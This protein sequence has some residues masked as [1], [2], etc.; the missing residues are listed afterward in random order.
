[1]TE[2]MKKQEELTKLLK[3]HC[4]AYYRDDNPELSD[5]EYDQLFLDLKAMEAATG[6]VFPG[7]PTQ[8]V[9]GDCL[10]FFEEVRHNTPM[11]S[12]DNVFNSEELL[13]WLNGLKA[14]IGRDVEY[15]IEPKLDGLA[16]R[17]LYRNGILETAATR[18]DGVVGENVTANARTIWNLPQRLD[19][20]NPPGVYEVSGEVVMSKKR[21]NALN[22]ARVERSEKPFATC[23]N[24]AAGSIRQLDS[25]VA[26]SRG[27]AFYAYQV[28]S[29]TTRLEHVAAM[30]EAASYGF[31][32]ALDVVKLPMR[33]QLG[34]ADLEDLLELWNGVRKEAAYDTDGLVFK[35]NEFVDQEQLGFTG[36]VPRWA[37]AYKFPAKEAT[38]KLRTVDFQV[39]R[40][41][42]ITP[43]ANFDTVNI[44]GVLVSRATIHNADELARLGIRYG[45]MLVV[46]RA[47]EV[48]PQI[49]RRYADPSVAE[50]GAP[51]VFPTNCPECGSLLERIPGEAE[52][53]C[54]NSNGCPAQ[55][56]NSLIHFASRK[57]LDIQGFGDRTVETF[58]NE[59]LLE[60]VTDFFTIFEDEDKKAIIRDLPGFGQRSIDVLEKSVYR[61]QSDKLELGRLIYALGIHNVGWSTARDFARWVLAN[62]RFEDLFKVGGFTAE[63]LMT[64]KDIGPVTSLAIVDYLK[65]P[66]NIAI[67]KDLREKLN[68]SLVKAEVQPLAGKVI[69]ITGSFVQVDREVLKNHLESLGAKVSGSVSGKTDFLLAG[70]DGGKKLSEALTLGVTIL[71]GEELFKQDWWVF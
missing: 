67:L 30:E 3:K 22:Q 17:V 18:G 14:T 11:L 37:I 35:V 6:V 60:T 21:F 15:L 19:T 68:I 45:D 66:E 23:R 56:Q 59:G 8:T 62:D 10:E 52:T 54:P 25:K 41:G 2:L 33:D 61:V 42:V 57:A 53:Y 38:S 28:S 5:C 39:G 70:N 36:R 69:V 50:L 26:A 44:D 47:G 51:V 4:R 58:Y 24:A 27:L 1:M 13:K 20:D 34:C 65:R 63:E 40:T 46:H 16:L 32:L 29:G 43:V 48:I 12:L 49:L 9:G 64:I 55:Q 71:Q 31:E 7:S